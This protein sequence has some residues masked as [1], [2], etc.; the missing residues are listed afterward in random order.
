MSRFIE[1]FKFTGSAMQEKGNFFALMFLA[2]AFG[3]LVVYF[4]VGWTSNIVAQVCC[5]PQLH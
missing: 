1:V 2:M 4:S 5:C 3:A